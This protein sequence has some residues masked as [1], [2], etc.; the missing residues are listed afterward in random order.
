MGYPSINDILLSNLIVTYRS[1]NCSTSPNVKSMFQKFKFC[2]KSSPSRINSQFWTQLSSWYRIQAEKSGSGKSSLYGFIQMF[3]YFV[4]ISI[5]TYISFDITNNLTR[6]PRVLSY[7][8]PP[9]V[10][11]YESAALEQAQVRR[12]SN[13]YL[14]CVF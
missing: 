9:P 11:S 4:L 12:I 10:E 2:W 5:L 8:V 13:I 3:Q 1:T 7:E 6:P 14:N